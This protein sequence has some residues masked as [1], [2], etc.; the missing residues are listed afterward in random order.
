MDREAREEAERQNRECV[1]SMSEW[2]AEVESR[3]FKD[4]PAIPYDP[5]RELRPC[6]LFQMSMM[7][8]VRMILPRLQCRSQSFQR[9]PLQQQAEPD[10]QL[11]TYR[12]ASKANSR[13][14]ELSDPQASST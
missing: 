1:R 11:S 7:L 13:S 14:G 6:E 12:G 3:G 4:H 8:F 10:Q 5:P 2:K 9:K